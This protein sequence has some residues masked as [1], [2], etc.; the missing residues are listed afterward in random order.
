MT[1]AVLNDTATTYKRLAYIAVAVKV[2]Y[3]FAMVSIR[4]ISLKYISRLPRRTSV[5]IFRGKEGILYIGKAANIKERVKT[6]FQQ[7]SFSDSLFINQ[8]SR[9]GYITTGSEIE[10]LLLEARLIKERRPK[11][12]VVWRDDK[13]YFY[14]AITKG[15]LPRIFI[16]HQ[17]KTKNLPLKIAYLGPFVDGGA[18]KQTLKFLRR[19]FPYYA[20]SGH[21]AGLCSWCHLNLCP[22]PNPNVNEYRKNIRN[23]VNILRGKKQS[24]L[25]TL[26]KE[27]AEVSAEENFEKAAKIRDRLRSLERTFS[28]AII[29]GWNG[30][31]KN[32]EKLWGSTRKELQKIFKTKKHISR[33]EACDIADIQGQQATGSIVTFINGKPE[34]KFYRKFKIKISA[35]PNDTAM[36]KETVCRR[37]RH[38]EWGMPDVLLIDGGKGQLNAA[39]QCLTTNKNIFAAALAKKHNELFIAG[40]KNPVLLKNCSP[41]VQNLILH[42]RDEAHRFAKVYHHHLRSKT[43]ENR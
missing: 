13:N 41:P 20:A 32:G 11:Y 12:N 22:G 31:A 27:M 1:V 15:R 6:H 28:N 30:G 5:Y 9:V 25:R 26:K 42:L 39:L 7:R 16:T 8:V 3:D 37:L 23:I 24:V 18:L 43:F 38:K 36:I 29:L 10:A 19:A 34:K 21:P 40:K 14:V 35:K 4:W 33:I 2:C 17:V